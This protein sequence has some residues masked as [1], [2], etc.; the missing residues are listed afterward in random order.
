MSSHAR[1]DRVRNRAADRAEEL[2]RRREDLEAGHPVTAKMPSGPLNVP[3]KRRIAPKPRSV[4]A[5][6]GHDRSAAADE[7]AA[8]LYDHAGHPRS[9]QEHRDAA[10]RDRTGAQPDRERADA[11]VEPTEPE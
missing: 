5:A 3:T 4:S 6:Q 11:A 9:A 10:R 8:E 1:R 7:S 2:A